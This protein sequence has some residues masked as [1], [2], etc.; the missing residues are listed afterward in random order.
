MY[1]GITVNIFETLLLFWG[2]GG[3][4]RGGGAGGGR[5]DKGPNFLIFIFLLGVT[6]MDKIKI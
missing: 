4:D 5:G 2:G 6:R 3:T 1:F